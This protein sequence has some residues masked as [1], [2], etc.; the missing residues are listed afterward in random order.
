MSEVIALPT[1]PQPLPV[2]HGLLVHLHSS[3]RPVNGHS[4]GTQKEGKRRNKNQ[5]NGFFSI[6]TKSFLQKKKNHPHC[7]SSSLIYFFLDHEKGEETIIET[8][9]DN[10]NGSYNFASI[11]LKARASIVFFTPTMLIKLVSP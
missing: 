4:L 8:H 5:S 10:K 11:E 7:F 2:Q 3:S 1:E 6:R 9:L